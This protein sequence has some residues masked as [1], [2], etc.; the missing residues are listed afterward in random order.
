MLLRHHLSARPEGVDGRGREQRWR[1]VH[2]ACACSG[3]RAAH[4]PG[5]VEG[6]AL[7]SDLG[8]KSS[9]VAKAYAVGDVHRELSGRNALGALG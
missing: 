4:E 9:M 5:P 7:L 3:L 6:T 1:Q 2:G 8:L